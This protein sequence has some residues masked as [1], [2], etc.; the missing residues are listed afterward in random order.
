VI[1]FRIMY[2][3]LCLCNFVTMV[4]CAFFI[5]DTRSSPMSHSEVSLRACVCVYV[6]VV[7]VYGATECILHHFHHLSPKVSL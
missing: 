3:F 1:L 6:C 5:H 4:L 7:P 2:F